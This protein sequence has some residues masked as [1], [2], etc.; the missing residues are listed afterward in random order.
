MRR[1][2]PFA[3]VGAVLISSTLA[4]IASS[5]HGRMNIGTSQSSIPYVLLIA[6]KNT[7]DA[8]FV[9]VTQTE[10][11]VARTGNSPKVTQKFEFEWPNR[12]ETT[13]RNVIVRG[14]RFG[15][16]IDI[17]STWY[18][19]AAPP[20]GCGGFQEITEPAHEYGTT[21]EAFAT[22]EPLRYALIASSFKVNN[23]VFEFF[24][25]KWHGAVEIRK[26]FVIKA[27]FD[28]S[29]P[30]TTFSSLA[31]VR[32][33]NAYSSFNSGAQIKAPSS[34]DV[35]KLRTGVHQVT[36]CDH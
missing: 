25:Q 28:Y 7:V 14:K 4:A 12:L 23:N 15:S 13:P 16:S 29:D 32:I 36:P 31:K 10:D 34:L 2:I 20:L 19:H 5:N 21:N 22:F 27:T 18:S 17:G 9:T 35:Q 24:G 6:I 11:V 3:F 8:R 1:L 33:D 26:Q 30:K